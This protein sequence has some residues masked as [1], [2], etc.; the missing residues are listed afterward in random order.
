MATLLNFVIL[1]EYKLNLLK[2][3]VDLFNPI[4]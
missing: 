2:N 4:G 1:E 3:P